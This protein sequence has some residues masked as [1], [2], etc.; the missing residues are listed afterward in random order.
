M[1][2]YCSQGEPLL[3]SSQRFSKCFHPESSE[4]QNT[5]RARA[6]TRLFALQGGL[7]IPALMAGEGGPSPSRRRGA[8]ASEPG[9]SRR[10]RRP[11]TCEL[12]AAPKACSVAIPKRQVPLEVRRWQAV[13]FFLPLYPFP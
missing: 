3:E 7:W 4:A 13:P 11:C 1:C 8:Q 12:R 10:K 5:T 9:R 6:H 2:E